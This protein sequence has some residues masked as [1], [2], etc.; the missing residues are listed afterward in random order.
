MYH[1]LYSSFVEFRLKCYFFFL[2]L[3]YLFLLNSLFIKLNPM[4][5]FFLTNLQ[6]LKNFHM[7]CH[8]EVCTSLLQE[9]WNIKSVRLSEFWGP[10]KVKLWCWIFVCWT[11]AFKML[12][13]PAACYSLMPLLMV[14]LIRAS[15]IYFSA[16]WFQMLQQDKIILLCIWSSVLFVFWGLKKKQQQNKQKSPSQ[17]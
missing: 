11:N 5:F 6:T 17:I 3:D 7:E 12:M 8:E 2:Y 4:V 15:A 16:W 13:Y 9:A 14:S 1:K 10:R